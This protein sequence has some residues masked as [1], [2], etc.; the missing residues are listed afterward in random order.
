MRSQ[1]N[2][3]G[4]TA[5]EI[6]M[7][8]TVIAI[9][10]LL[11]LPVFRQ[12]AEEARLAAANDE[13]QSIVKTLLLIEADMPGGAFMP[14][15][16][17]LDNRSNP[18]KVAGVND[19]PDL[20]PARTTW[21]ST[22]PGTTRAGF[23]LLSDAEYNATVPQNWQGPYVAV[24]NSRTLD[25]I[26]LA[27][28]QAV[29]RA[30]GGSGTT[31]ISSGTGPIWIYDNYDDLF[32]DRYPVDPWGSPYLLFGTEETIYNVRAVYSMGPDGVP[33]ENNPNPLPT[34]Y[35]RRGGRLGTGDDLFFF[36]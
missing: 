20:D 25:E 14:R 22:V 21:R 30:N 13:L 4:F 24:K 2:R 34:D 28:P 15:L 33:G 26:D 5:I 29:T 17:D 8:A 35:D 31:T 32:A 1:P 11:I 19:V 12:R 23:Y 10:A 16:N 3:R 36:F 7:V 9:L 27:Y 6:A 18:G